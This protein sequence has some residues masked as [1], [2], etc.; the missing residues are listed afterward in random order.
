[1][2]WQLSC[3]FLSSFA[4]VFLNLGFCFW[5][6]FLVLFCFVLFFLSLFISVGIRS[7]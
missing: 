5:F 1:M 6:F 2:Y 7:I 3:H 4:N